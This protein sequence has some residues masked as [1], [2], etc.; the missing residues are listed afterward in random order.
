V[1]T[2]NRLI[3]L[4]RMTL[5]GWHTKHAA[6]DIR[7]ARLGMGSHMTRQKIAR[8]LAGARLGP[9]ASVR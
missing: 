8:T 1:R 2:V 5:P 3:A 9:I 7:T 6:A 4:T